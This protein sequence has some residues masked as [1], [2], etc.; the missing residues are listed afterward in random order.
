MDLSEVFSAPQIWAQDMVLD[1]EHPGAGTVRM[2]EFPV[3]LSD[4]PARLRLPV[5]VLGADTD[6][7]LREFGYS[8]ERIAALREGQD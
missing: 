7:V 6:A 2:T 3:K 8:A 5:P 1:V 4:A